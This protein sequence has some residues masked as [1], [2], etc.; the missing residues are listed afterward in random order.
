MQIVSH[1]WHRHFSKHRDGTLSWENE[2]DA[3]S[4]HCCECVSRKC[5]RSNLRKENYL[6]ISLVVCVFVYACSRHSTNYSLETI[7]AL[8][9]ARNVHLHK[10]I[11]TGTPKQTTIYMSL[12]RNYWSFDNIGKLLVLQLHIF[13]EVTLEICITSDAFTGIY[14]I[15]FPFAPKSF[16]SLRKHLSKMNFELETLYA[17]T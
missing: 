13:V 15:S 3:M 1:H 4:V 11:H 17:A 9:T 7:S 10:H 6:P 5:R 2:N 12:T 16:K 14:F 8:P